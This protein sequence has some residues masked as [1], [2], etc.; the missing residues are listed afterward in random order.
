MLVL[1]KGFRHQQI[2]WRYF[3]FDNIQDGGKQHVTLASA[4]LSHSLSA[5]MSLDGQ[6]EGNLQQ[7]Y[8]VLPQG[9]HPK[10]P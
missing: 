1:G 3:R 10:T 6:Q 7:Y 2:E 9:G 5:F 8:R 4:G